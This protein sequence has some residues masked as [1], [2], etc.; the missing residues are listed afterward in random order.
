MNG[1]V[2]VDEEKCVGC[3]KC[4][5]NCIVLDAN[6][7]KMTE[8]G[9]VVEVNE[10]KCVLCG[11]CIE[12]CDHDARGFTD[13]TELFFEDLQK[14]TRISVIAAPAVRA[15][16]ENYENLFGF[17]KAKGVNVI[18][19]VSF[20]ADIT[21]W[22]Y[23]KA[24]KDNDLKTVLAQPCPVIVSYIERYKSELIDKLSPIHSPMMCTAVY[25][26]KYA[27]IDGKIAFLSPCI[28][29]TNEINDENTFGYIN[30]NVTFKKLKEYIDNN[31]ININ[32]YNAVKFEDIGCSM[33]ILYSRPGGL[34]ENVEIKVPG[35]WVRQIEGHNH[36]YP[37][38]DEYAERLERNKPVPLLVDILNCT[39][40]CNIGTATTKDIQIDDI[41]NKFNG[42]KQEK[43][44]EKTSL[45]QKRFDW[46]FKYFDK[47]L[48]IA[49]F[50]RKYNKFLKVKKLSEPTRL[51]SEKIYSQLLKETEKDKNLNCS[52]CGYHN[53]KDMVKAILNDLNYI[54]N[55][56]HHNRKQILVEKNNF[57][58]SA[59]KMTAMINKISKAS[60]LAYSNTDEVNNLF[61][62]IVDNAS[63]VSDFTK[64]ISSSVSGVVITMKEITHSLN[65][66]SSNCERSKTIT[67]NAEKR[68][69]DTN[70]MMD[71]LNESS[72]NIVKIVNVIDDI[73]GQTN[74]L[75]LNAAIEAVGAGESGKGFAVVAGEVKELAKQTAQSTDE[76]A[77]Q[78]S[79]MQN[80]INVAVSAM[81][82][83]SGVI[84]EITGI[85]NNIAAAISEQT[86]VSGNISSTTINAA[87]K[88]SKITENMGDIAKKTNVASGSIG[89]VFM[90]IKELC[91]E[92]SKI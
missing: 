54:D 71:K 55:C 16:Y 61:K 2:T 53:C 92:T 39:H 31:N 88:L 24:I 68:A 4:I 91:D 77:S 41:D 36:A 83:I 64:D 73:A 72:R 15:N 81:K 75:A 23:L 27:Q 26:K 59:T 37:Y 35:A 44:N 22:A 13:D 43:I 90:S 5:R 85:T 12:V 20:G 49:D 34:R 8:N 84:A 79:N 80:N 56:A 67:E 6:V 3:N 11:K 63:N 58:E 10:E 89:E 9:N 86:T 7:A 87:E 33:G 14:G 46:I 28:G 32:N 82:S 38:L 78:I 69:L 70:K 50:G 17:L 21:T 62:Q 76:I 1:K 52:A 30:Y 40:G 51:E 25:L 42:L 47:H 60:E 57:E 65:E 48:D 19:D 29:K 74:M 18:Y 45:V 66:I